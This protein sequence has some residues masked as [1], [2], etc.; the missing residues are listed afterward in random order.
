MEVG[1]LSMDLECVKRELASGSGDIT[2]RLRTC[3]TCLIGSECMF[4][5]RS[6]SLTRQSAAVMLCV[7][8]LCDFDDVDMLDASDLT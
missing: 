3:I 8:W 1:G 6:A 4:S 7:N 5:R 2:M